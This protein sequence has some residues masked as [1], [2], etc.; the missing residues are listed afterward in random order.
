MQWQWRAKEMSNL[1]LDGLAKLDS[2]GHWKE[3]HPAHV[4]APDFSILHL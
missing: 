2:S 3:Q 4:V 1:G